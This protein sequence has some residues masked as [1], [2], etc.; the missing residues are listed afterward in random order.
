VSP[1]RLQ[2]A[3]KEWAVVVEALREGRQI[4]LLR[5][6][7]IHDPRGEFRPS[8]REFL[9]FPTFEHQRPELLKPDAASRWAGLL[10]PGAEARPLRLDA[11]AELVEAV[12]L[13]D[14]EAA[15]RL[16]PH[17]VWSPEYIETRLAYKPERPLTV[18]LLRA[19]L[20]PHAVE[21]PRLE[22]Y[23]GC[24]SW[25]ELAEEVSTAGARPALGDE[26]FAARV[27]EVRGCI[28]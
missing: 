14:A 26:E 12:P 17:H 16:A 21:I 22:R 4:V 20:L 1:A 18:L 8:R 28:V 19:Y 10:D 6:G 3:L 9:F 25:V 27:E 5:K 23:A 15:R 24:R 11:C 7:G 2:Q 13:P